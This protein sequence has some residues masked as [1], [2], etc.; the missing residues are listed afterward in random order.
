MIHLPPLSPGYTVS[1]ITVNNSG[2][3][4][5]T[6]VFFKPAANLTQVSLTPP[7]TSSSLTHTQYNLQPY[8]P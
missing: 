7:V 3:A 1:A 6:G 5:I 2:G 4:F 8:S